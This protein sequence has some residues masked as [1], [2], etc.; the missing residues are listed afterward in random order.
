MST[1]YTQLT[2]EERYHVYLM[3]KTCVSIRK[4]A[5]G[6]NRHHTTISRELKQNS[7]KRGYR[8]KQAQAKAKK[9]HADKVK[10][11]QTFR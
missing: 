3:C 10:K 4:I 6:M 1:K 8:P 5:E 7:G 9:R 11:K 2:S